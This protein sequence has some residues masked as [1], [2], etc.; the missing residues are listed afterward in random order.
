[1]L[2][3]LF[4]MFPL[5]ALPTKLVGNEA[6][7]SFKIENEDGSPKKRK[8]GGEEEEEKEEIA[9][10]VRPVVREITYFHTVL[11]RQSISSPSRC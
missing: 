5:A 10:P 4:K 7:I 8:K 3:K 11:L 9:K 2:K 6:M 1:M